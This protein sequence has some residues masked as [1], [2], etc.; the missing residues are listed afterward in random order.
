[1]SAFLLSLTDERVSCHSG[2]FDHPEL[3]LSMGHLEM[4]STKSQMARD[5]VRI[6]P[7]TGR[8]GLK[9]AGNLLSEFRLA[10]RLRQ[11]ARPATAAGRVHGHP[12]DPDVFHMRFFGPDSANVVQTAAIDTVTLPSNVTVTTSMVTPTAGM[13]PTSVAAPAAQDTGLDVATVPGVADPF[14]TRA[15]TA[16]PPAIFTPAAGTVTITPPAPPAV[17]APTL[18]TAIRNIHA[19]TAIGFV[20]KATVSNASCPTLPRRQWG[21]GGRERHQRRHP[22]QHHP[23]DA[24]Q[25]ADMGGDAPSIAGRRRHGD[26]EPA[27]ASADRRRHL[28]LHELRIEGNIVD[29]AT[30]RA[31]STCRSSRSTR[32]QATSP[33]STTPLA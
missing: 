28:P 29:G 13:I 2:A 6:L 19:F 1:M 7:A 31:S 33:A 10:V 32:R 8:Y 17:P 18:S 26:D 15:G 3:P 14:G 23:P 22:M 4:A 16:R 24:G 11:R 30:S 20:Q 12:G 9:A 25:H 27:A 21:H 5:V